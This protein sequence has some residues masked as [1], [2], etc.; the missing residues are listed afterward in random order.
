M[1][2]LAVLLW[3]IPR[4]KLKVSVERTGSRPRDNDSATVEPR[5][6]QLHYEPR[7]LATGAR[8]DDNLIRE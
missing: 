7:V 4:R 2:L 8:L 1:V 5:I 6:G 3:F